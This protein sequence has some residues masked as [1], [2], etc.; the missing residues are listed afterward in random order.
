[1]LIKINLIVISVNFMDLFQVGTHI[2]N[3]IIF[4]PNSLL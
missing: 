1:M 4:S 3:V 2:K